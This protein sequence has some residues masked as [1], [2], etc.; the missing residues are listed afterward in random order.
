MEVERSSNESLRSTGLNTVS[1]STS[2]KTIRFLR[3]FDDTLFTTPPDEELIL[4][5]QRLDVMDK[6]TKVLFENGHL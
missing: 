1:R 2:R 6:Q 4:F 5:M 3:D